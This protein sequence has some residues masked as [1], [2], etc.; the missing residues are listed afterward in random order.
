MALSRV[1]AVLLTLVPALVVSPSPSSA[2]AP[3]FHELWRAGQHDGFTGWALAGVQVSDGRLV[4][5]AAAIRAGDGLPAERPDD[6]ATV[7]AGVATAVGLALGPVRETAEP[8]TELIPSWNAATPPGTW[9]EIRV[10][11]RIGD[12]WTGWYAFG[13]WST[14][15]APGRRASVADQRNEDGRVLTDTLR[16]RAS[17]E[18]YQLA[19]SL[20]ADDPARSPSVEMAAMLASRPSPTAR[21]LAADRSTWG[22]VLDVTE[23]SQMVY[24][25]G[26]PVWCSPTSTSMVLAYWSDQ[27]GAPVLSRPVP[28]V[29][30][31]VY[32]PVYRGNGNWSF[33]VAYAGREGLTAYVS[34]MSSVAQ[35]ERWIAAGVPVVASLA[36]DPGDLPNASVPSTNGHLLVVVGLTDD[37]QVVV[38]DPAADPRRGQSVRRVYDRA[39]FESLWLEHSGGTVYLIHPSTQ[40]PPSADAYGAW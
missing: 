14:D 9:V 28:E 40:A 32:D 3:P 37:G 30:A 13:S 38:N 8:F 20:H 2:A 4:L 5:D 7:P 26:G 18:A 33:N 1:L 21:D 11:V 12:R 16:L 27:L 35:I 29:A 34:R 19:L 22:T 24:P 36:W 17:S 6:L 39:R 15:D 23:R 31:A 25:N 10:R